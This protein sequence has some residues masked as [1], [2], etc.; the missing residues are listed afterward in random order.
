MEDQLF[1][2]GA[3]PTNM[4]QQ[5]ENANPE[6]QPI[7]P[8]RL[9]VDPLKYIQMLRPFTGKTEEL[10]H[11]IGMIDAIAPVIIQYDKLSQQMLIEAIKSK[12]KGKARLVMNIYPHYRSWEEIKALMIANI[13]YFQIIK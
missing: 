12:I 11:F 1:N 2:T 9:E 8:R 6:Q 4:Q 7:K 3:F 5:Q 13:T 10:Q